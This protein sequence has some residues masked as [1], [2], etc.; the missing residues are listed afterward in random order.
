L[1]GHSGHS[2]KRLSRQV[3]NLNL[4]STWPQAERPLPSQRMHTIAS[5]RTWWFH[6]HP[7]GEIIS[8]L[9]QLYRRKRAGMLRLLRPKR[10]SM[11]NIND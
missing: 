8:E 11:S 10:L 4:P 3:W 5:K 6:Q 7:A 2:L 1:I 9:S